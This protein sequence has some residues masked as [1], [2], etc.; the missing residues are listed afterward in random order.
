M[1]GSSRAE[2]AAHNAFRP[3]GEKGEENSVAAELFH[4]QVTRS[5]GIFSCRQVIRC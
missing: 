5:R 4:A 3:F 2:F 1:E